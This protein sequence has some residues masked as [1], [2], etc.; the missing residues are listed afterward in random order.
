MDNIEKLVN[1]LLKDKNLIDQTPEKE[2]TMDDVKR[3]MSL[4]SLT[5]LVI[6]DQV[7]YLTDRVAKLENN[8]G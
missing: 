2:L 5:F 8:V 7:T 4:T 1:D 6:M 3:F